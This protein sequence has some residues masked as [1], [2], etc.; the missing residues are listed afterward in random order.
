MSILV[1]TLGR[2]RAYPRR[3]AT[4]NV[5]QSK[6]DQTEIEFTKFNDAIAIKDLTITDLEAKLAE[7]K[8]DRADYEKLS[9]EKNF[10]DHEVQV[11]QL[12]IQEDGEHG[13]NE[14]SKMN[15]SLLLKITELEES[16]FNQR[17]THCEQDQQIMDLR[18]KLDEFAVPHHRKNTRNCC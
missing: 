4:Q 5:Q 14:A 13:K 16:N 10:L 1:Y 15:D 18:M 3:P 17:R 9:M 6:H 8:R 12:Q 2:H 11:L 7:T